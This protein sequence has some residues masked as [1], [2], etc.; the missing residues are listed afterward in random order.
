MRIRSFARPLSTM[1]RA[2]HCVFGFLLFWA[3]VLI[4]GTKPAFPIVVCHDYTLYRVTCSNGRCEDSNNLLPSGRGGLRERLSSM[5]YKGF[6]ITN[7]ALGDLA[8]AHSSLKPGDVLF[9]REAHSGFVNDNYTIDHFLQL[10]G[11]IGRPRA[12]NSLPL[13]VE[14]SGQRGGLFLGHTLEQF[15]KAPIV[16]VPLGSLEVWRRANNPAKPKGRAAFDLDGTW[17]ATI[18]DQS[19]TEKLVWQLTSGK[20]SSTIDWSLR[21]TLLTTTKPSRQQFV[22]QTWSDGYLEFREDHGKWYY[23]RN[24]GVFAFNQSAE[25]FVVNGSISCDGKQG[26]FN[27]DW[28]IKIQAVK[29]GGS[30]QQP[31]QGNSPVGQ[32]RPQASNTAT[33][34]RRMPRFSAEQVNAIRQWIAYYDSLV[35]KWTQYRDQT[36]APYLNNGVYY[37]W[38]RSEYQRSNQQIQL[39][40]QWKTYYQNALRQ[41][42]L[43]N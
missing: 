22:N 20:S 5:G 38:A 19:G 39:A 29:K 10:L 33:P 37:Q 8:L 17:D 12:A 7:T 1:G 18:T 6:S 4:F 25:C 15:L 3:V 9:I 31:G 32:N 42:G 24:R 30:S 28:A 41:V 11:E 2:R 23:G 43:S 34:P 16:Q 13:F 26:E 40:K 14:G 35:M 36:V 27:R 21:S